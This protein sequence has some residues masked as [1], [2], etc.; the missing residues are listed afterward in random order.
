MFAL[1]RFAIQFVENSEEAKGDDALDK[2]LGRCGIDPALILD[3][4]PD[5]PALAEAPLFDLLT[6]PVKELLA[7]LK[8]LVEGV[9]RAEDRAEVCCAVADEPEVG[10]PTPGN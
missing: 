6:P 9:G 7:G 5:L 3:N 2:R 8:G 10:A 1:S 4:S